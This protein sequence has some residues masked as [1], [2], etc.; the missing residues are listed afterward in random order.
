M[1]LPLC[2]VVGL[3][4]VLIALSVIPFGGLSAP[5]ILEAICFCWPLS[6]GLMRFLPLLQRWTR[7]AFEGMGASREVQFS[8]S[9]QSLFAAWTRRD[10]L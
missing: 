6:L 8:G 4:S 2:P 10:C 7:S 9:W 1:D 5:F 3:A